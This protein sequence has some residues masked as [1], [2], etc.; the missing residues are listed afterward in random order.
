MVWWSVQ[1][2]KFSIQFSTKKNPT[3]F[4][5][6][7]LFRN[8]EYPQ[9]VNQK[10]QAKNIADTLLTKQGKSYA[11]WLVSFFEFINYVCY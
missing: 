9:N 3:N 4:W 11:C 2:I 10:L 1:V 5:F 6:L 8:K 7:F